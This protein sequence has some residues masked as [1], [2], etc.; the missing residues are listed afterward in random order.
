MRDRSSQLPQRN[1]AFRRP[2]STAPGIALLVMTLGLAPAA[3][4]PQEEPID[5]S[6][7]Q[8]ISVSEVAGLGEASLR[9]VAQWG[10]RIVWISGSAGTVRRSLDGG[11]TW[12]DVAPQDS[13]ELDFR[14]IA[15]LDPD[16]ILLMSAGPDEAS[17]IY[18]TSDGGASWRRVLQATTAGAFFNGFD[19]TAATG[20]AG[21]RGLLTSDSADGRLLLLQTEDDGETW[22]RVGETSLPPLVDGEAGFAA[23]GTGVVTRG[24]HSWIATGGAAARVFHSQDRGQQWNVYPTPMVSG[25][26]SQGIF[27]IAF[28]DTDH[29]VIVGGDYQ[30]PDAAPAADRGSIAWT[31]DGGHRWTLATSDQPVEQK[32]CVRY[33]SESLVLAAGRSGLL[34]SRDGGH[35]WEIQPGPAYY[36]FD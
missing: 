5:R 21:A 12:S 28:L 34:V 33:L 30:N 19:F 36:A 31:D 35:H 25:S 17:R 27:S 6:G 18:K 11:A 29:G 10:D 16:T 15:I 20:G 9:G 14:D 24:A 7:T 26:P 32:A 13:S 23:S 8:Q 3:A 22:Q 2:T 4:I 1:S